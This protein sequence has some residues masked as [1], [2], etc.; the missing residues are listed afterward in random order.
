MGLL[1][2]YI[3]IKYSGSSTNKR[4]DIPKFLGLQM[5]F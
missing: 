1:D 3:Q 4:I 5:K 2:D